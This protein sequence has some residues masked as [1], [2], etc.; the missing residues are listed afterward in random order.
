MKANTSAYYRIASPVNSANVLLIG[1][2]GHLGQTLRHYAPKV[3]KLHC[4]SSAELDLCNHDAVRH[5]I[6]KQVGEQ[7]PREAQ[8]GLSTSTAAMTA[9]QGNSHSSSWVVINAAAYTQVDAAE[10]QRVP[11][12]A[13]NATAVGNLAQLCAQYALPLLHFSTDYVFD[14]KKQDPY[15]PADSPNPLNYYGYSK[16]LGEQL[17]Q[18]YHPQHWLWRVSWL[19]GPLGRNF[20]QN[21]IARL[22][23]PNPPQ[24]LPMVQDQIGSP[25]F[26]P[27]L[28][29]TV[30]QVVLDY[31][32]AQGVL[33]AQSGIKTTARQT[34]PL[35][36]GL[37]H[38]CTHLP[39][40]RY[41]YAKQVLQQAQTQ[42]L[43]TQIPILE[44][45]TLQEF[46]APAVRPYYSALQCCAELSAIVER[47]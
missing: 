15:T 11:A 19:H 14:G 17:L 8:P 47:C 2:S 5:Y 29:Q 42:G 24:S 3:I 39:C 4:P 45:A 31:F 46:S 21:L 9:H 32:V 7:R 18:R 35:P 22:Q 25:T 23:G 41:A 20:A 40:S 27:Q 37:Y 28:A 38:Y 10:T 44:P 43:I 1:A 34:N 26:S 30:W 13:L 16:H 12:K 6:A 36:W 33:K